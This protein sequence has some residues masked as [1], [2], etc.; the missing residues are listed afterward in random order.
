MTFSPNHKT[1][2]VIDQSRQFLRRTCQQTVEFD[3]LTKTRQPIT[4]IIP[5][6]P[7]SKSLWTC[8]VEAITEYCRIVWDIFP[9]GE[10]LIRF[11]AADVD[12]AYFINRWA[13]EEQNLSSCME[14]FAKASALASLKRA[15]GSI[16]H[17][18]NTVIMNGL[19]KAINALCEMSHIQ[20]EKRKKDFDQGAIS[21]RGRIVCI[22]SFRNDT[23]I[24]SLED[25]FYEAL[26]Q[27]NKLVCSNAQSENT[28]IFPVN[29]CELIFLNTFPIEDQ[30]PTSM[31]MEIPRHERSLVST[32]VYSVKSGKFLAAKLGYLV[33]KHYDLA[34]TTVT[35]I[36][37]KEEQ[38]ASSSANYDVEI[39][40]PYMAHFDLFKSLAINVEGLCVKTSREGVTYDTVSLKWCTPRSSSVELHYCTSSYRIT[41]IEVNSRP[42]LCLTNFLLSGR[43]VMLEMPRSK[44]SKIL[45]HMLSSH[46]GEL[47]IHTLGTGRSVLEDPP[48]ISEGSG[49]RVTDYRINDYGEFMKKNS[50]VMCRAIQNTNKETLVPIE[51]AKQSLIRQTLYYPMVIGHS[52]LFNI[53]PQ[54]QQFL[55]LIPKDS[56]TVDD[57]NEC[58][59]VIYQIVGM[60][61]KGIQK[62][63][64]QF[65]SYKKHVN[66]FKFSKKDFILQY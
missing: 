2:F 35:G 65:K 20:I 19:T 22:S 45:S 10:R 31:I 46:C 39:V 18:D 62:N 57:I 59:K 60:E 30:S 11:V 63:G 47:Y 52:V 61:S 8:T 33:L 40:H 51:K 34:S 58:K 36:P 43:S 14:S 13:P 41:S 25:C 27:H 6:A 66:L 9:K 44:G 38:N 53:Q 64:K 24:R 16:S 21:N 55:N 17:D 37:M 49:G 12:E 48:S 50:L 42:S 54:V 15:H 56:L 7:I 26:Q 1:V 5:L 29:H 32:E 4:G 23:H 28:N 3:V